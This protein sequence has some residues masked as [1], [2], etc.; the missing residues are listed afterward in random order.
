METTTNVVI[1]S[2]AKDQGACPER[3]ERV[4]EAFGY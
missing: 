4:V 2:N 1:L 3:S